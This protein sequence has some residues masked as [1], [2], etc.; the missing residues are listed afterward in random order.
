MGTVHYLP[1]TH[2]VRST[3]T[4]RLGQGGSLTKMAALSHLRVL[5]RMEAFLCGRVRLLF[6]CR[7]QTSTWT[8]SDEPS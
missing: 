7:D 3:N 5:P 2:P 4:L 6:W 1:T 8:K